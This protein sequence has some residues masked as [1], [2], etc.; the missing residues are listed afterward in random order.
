MRREHPPRFPKP[1]FGSGGRNECN[2]EMLRSPFVTSRPLPC[3]VKFWHEQGFEVPTNAE[4][5]DHPV[6]LG[7]FTRH[8]LTP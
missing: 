3:A 4:E 5:A 8:K 2:T 6:P 1:F 7:Y